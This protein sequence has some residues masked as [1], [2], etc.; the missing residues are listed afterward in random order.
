MRWILATLVAVSFTF[1]LF[2]TATDSVS[3]NE[4]YYHRQM[5]ENKIP[6][7]TGKSLKELDRIS[8]ALRVY[9]KQGDPRVL[10][11]HFNE[12]E[13]DHMADVYALFHLMR[14][15]C[16]VAAIV[17]TT[18]FFALAKKF[19]VKEGLRSI[20]R[21]ALALVATFLILGGG[22][23]MNF[24]ET[25]YTFHTLFFSNK[26]WLMDPA[27]DLIIKMLPEAFF[28]G[29][30]KQIGLIM[31]VGLLIVASFAFLKGSKHE[32]K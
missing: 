20:G 9:L 26:L 27:T 6:A 10:T 14:R 15:L 1:L 19:G 7:E 24:T 18:G 25:W 4:A 22:I 13:V 2:G 21:A 12:N 17:A 30:V 31:A 5:I 11:P 16:V 32:I 8:T 28:F 3:G 23:A 29:M